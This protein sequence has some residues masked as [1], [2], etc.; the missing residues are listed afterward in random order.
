MVRVE[1]TEEVNQE[2]R[3]KETLTSENKRASSQKVRKYK[4]NPLLGAHV[5]VHVH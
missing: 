5:Q 3:I 2:G 4:S 1:E